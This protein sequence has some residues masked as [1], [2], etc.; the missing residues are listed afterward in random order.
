M[1]RLYPPQIEGTLPA[2]CKG[3]EL[4]IPFM[5]NKT[6]GWNEVIGFYLKVK[7]IQTNETLMTLIKMFI[8][9]EWL[10][11]QQME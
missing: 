4:A 3:E 7:S 5:M 11:T 6:V 8:L 10:P 9:V 2:Y 1:A